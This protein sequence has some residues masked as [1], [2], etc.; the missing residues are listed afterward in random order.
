MEF[1]VARLDSQKH[2][3]RLQLQLLTRRSALSVLASDT[4]NPSWRPVP[5]QRHLI[6]IA[7]AFLALRPQPLRPGSWV[8]SPFQ[9]G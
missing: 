4:T 1:F 7:V 3:P 6:S 2:I 5:C 8:F 9:G